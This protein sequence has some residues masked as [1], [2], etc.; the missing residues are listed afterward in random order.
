MSLQP[1]LRA[2]SAA[3]PQLRRTR[4]ALRQCAL[5]N[6]PP[7]PAM[8][9]VLHPLAPAPAR[10]DNSRARLRRLLPQLQKIP[11]IM[12]PCCRPIPWISPSCPCCLPMCRKP[13]RP[14][15][16]WT[17]LP[18]PHFR[19]PVR[20]RLWIFLQAHAAQA[21]Q[22]SFGAASSV[23]RHHFRRHYFSRHWSSPPASPRRRVLSP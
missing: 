5:R 8:A 21:P 6:S 15:R 10:P 1:R 23:A 22:A 12:L 9:R 11:R 17:L 14:Q 16:Q 7:R 19:C 2:S 13:H 18:I 3:P 4:Q 20:Q